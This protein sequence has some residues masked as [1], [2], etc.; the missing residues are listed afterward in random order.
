MGNIQDLYDLLASCT[1]ML[2]TKILDYLQEDNGR[3]SAI[4]D[5]AIASTRS[6]GTLNLSLKALMQESMDDF[7]RLDEILGFELF[8]DLIAYKGNVMDFLRIVSRMLTATSDKILDVFMSD[9]NKLSMVVERTIKDRVSLGTMGL[10]LYDFD[11]VMLARIE[12]LFSARIYMELCRRNGNLPILMGIMQHS[13]VKRQIELAEMLKQNQ[14]QK[15]ELLNNTIEDE[16]KIGTFALCLK[17]LKDENEE[18]LVLFE[19]A[20]GTNGFLKLIRPP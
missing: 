18:C 3:T 20:I 9:S 16:K 4:L 14:K 15:N 11:D 10:V 17:S 8:I 2:R 19:E 12:E 7:E 5:K 6:I 1:S 13:S